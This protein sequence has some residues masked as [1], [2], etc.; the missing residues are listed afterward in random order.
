MQTKILPT[1]NLH[2]LRGTE[3]SDPRSLLHGDVDPDQE[4]IATF[5]RA[6]SVGA[7]PRAIGGQ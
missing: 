6:N 1:K 5:S 4:K 3:A 7:S 2:F